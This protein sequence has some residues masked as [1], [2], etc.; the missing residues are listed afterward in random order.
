LY[1]FKCLFAL[2]FHIP[3]NSAVVS[4]LMGSARKSINNSV[5]FFIIYVP[6]Q[7][8]QGQ[9]QAQHSVDNNNNNK[10]TKDTN[11]LFL[12]PQCLPLI[13]HSAGFKHFK[14]LCYHWY[15]YNLFYFS[16]LLM[17]ILIIH[18]LIIIIIIIII[19]IYCLILYF[20][21]KFW[22]ISFYA[23]VLSL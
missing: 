3:T 17:I 9:L 11:L 20:V 18:G 16:H 14:K 13:E 1:L 6:S 21:C 12:F 8:P 2:L 15:Y 22:V 7:Q 19:I 10:G 4:W 5:Q 23:L